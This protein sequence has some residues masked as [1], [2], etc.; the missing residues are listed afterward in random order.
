MDERAQKRRSGATGEIAFSL[1]VQSE[2]AAS[3]RVFVEILDEGARLTEVGLRELAA[4]ESLSP[5]R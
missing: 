2:A 4:G 1:E 5:E 3:D